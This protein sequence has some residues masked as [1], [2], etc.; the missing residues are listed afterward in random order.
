MLK[1]IGKWKNSQ[2]CSRK[3]NIFLIWASEKRNVCFDSWH[4]WWETILFSMCSTITTPN[5]SVLFSWTYDSMDLRFFMDLS[6][7]VKPWVSVWSSA[8]L[9]VWDLQKNESK[10]CTGLWLGV[11]PK[12]SVELSTICLSLTDS[13]N[14]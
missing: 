4:S 5:V 8:G 6:E 7:K 11:Q 10:T 12:L 3:P 14:Y 13:Q 9:K 2:D 1:F